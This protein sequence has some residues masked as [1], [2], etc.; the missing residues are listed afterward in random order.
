MNP[1]FRAFFACLSV[2][3]LL[4]RLFFLPFPAFFQKMREKSAVRK[5]FAPKTVYGLFAPRKGPTENLN[6]RS[7]YFFNALRQTV[8]LF[9]FRFRTGVSRSAFC[10]FP[11]FFKKCGKNR[12]SERL[13]LQRRFTGFSLREK[14]RPRILITVHLTFSTPC[15]KRFGFFL[16][17]SERGY[18]ARLFAFSRIFSKNAGKIG[19]PKSF[20]SKDG[21]RTFRSAKR[22]DRESFSPEK[23]FALL[24]Q[25]LAANGSVFSFRFRTG[26]SRS[27]FAPFPV[28]FRKMREKSAVRKVFVLKT[29][30]GLFAPRKSPTENLFLPKNRSSYFFNAL[31]Q[32]VRF[33]SFRFRTGVSRSVF[34]LFPHF[35][36]KCGKNRLSE[37]LSR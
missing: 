23:P 8:R 34:C 16:F 33:F 18:P 35:F 14:V 10:L 12:L 19:C 15:G 27:A 1:V 29:V 21:F 22:S 11:H 7:S 28:L 31:R 20:R 3:V 5:A 2:R 30:S 17:D 9:S 36:E 26:F 32:T 4:S 13:S 25:R 37:R 6:N 24:F